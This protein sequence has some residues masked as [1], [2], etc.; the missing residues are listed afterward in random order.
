MLTSIHLYASEWRTSAHLASPRHLFRV[1]II[2]QNNSWA[3]TC[4]DIKENK[5]CPSRRPLISELQSCIDKIYSTAN[6]HHRPSGET[7]DVHR[8]AFAS[9][10]KKRENVSPGEISWRLTDWIQAVDFNVSICSRPNINL[11]QLITQTSLLKPA[12]T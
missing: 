6:N 3:Q 2:I 4:T 12:H 7:G 9:C 8:Q 10:I 1:R 5:G 11:R